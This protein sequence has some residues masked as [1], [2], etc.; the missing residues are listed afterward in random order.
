MMMM[1]GNGGWK[2][3]EKELLLQMNVVVL[4]LFEY[5]LIRSNPNGH[6]TSL[7]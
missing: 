1:R 4:Q 3:R 2:K 7:L 5:I 6:S